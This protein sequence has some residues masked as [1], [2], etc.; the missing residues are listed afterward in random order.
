LASY[1]L[2]LLRR[3]IG[4]KLS[5]ANVIT[6]LSSD[7][8]KSMSEETYEVFCSDYV[9]ERFQHYNKA[10][11]NNNTGTRKATTFMYVRKQT[12]I[13]KLHSERLQHY[14]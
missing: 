7:K 4:K 5:R 14:F 2:L 3:T 8:K 10:F 6:V 13:V 12:K 11:R 1:N 9:A